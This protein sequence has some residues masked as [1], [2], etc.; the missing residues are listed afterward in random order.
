MFIDF[1]FNDL[2]AKNV[3]VAVSGG[4]DSMALLFLLYSIKDKYGF[5]LCAVNVEH[6]I[7]GK[8]SLDDTNFVKSYCNEKNIPIFCFSVDCLNHSKA[9]KL[10]LE[11]SA[12]ILRYECFYSLLNSKKCD[13]IAT[14]HHQSDNAE[15]TLFNIFRGCGIDG[16]CGIENYSN[17]I[18]RPLLSVSKKEILA[19]I[20]DNDV[21]FVTDETNF[22]D[23]YTRNYLRQNV[24]PKIK[25]VF[26]EFEKSLYRLSQ[27]AKENTEYI[28]SKAEE[29]IKIID[30]HTVA[31]NLPVDKPIFFKCVILALNNL[32]VNKDW[33]KKHIDSAYELTRNQTG[34]RIDFPFGITVY[35]EGEN[36]VFTK[37]TNS[38]FTSIPF[39]PNDF[40]FL[41]KKYKITTL[42]EKPNLV[43]IALACA[44][45]CLIS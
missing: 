6:G 25:E 7:R 20:K 32:N 22:C 3:C 12:R 10:S 45:A 31:I 13:V 1:N 30:Q 19:F 39:S 16:L 26:P 43:T 15:S 8:S 37:N 2:Y 14:A 27:I 11:E 23:D 4:A 21:P 36:L 17:Q 44:V 42:S 18:I 38:I 34:K 24:I 33:E 40:E 5:S 29:R 41:G 28:L 9:N 35:K